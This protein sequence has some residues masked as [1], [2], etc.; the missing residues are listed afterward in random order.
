[1][2]LVGHGVRRPGAGPH[3]PYDVAGG[4]EQQ[5]GS[6]AEGHG[7]SGAPYS[8]TGCAPWPTDPSF[9]PVRVSRRLHVRRAAGER[10]RGDLTASL[11]PAAAGT[12][13]LSWTLIRGRARW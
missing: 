7:E 5:Q 9:V 1:M 10:A 6:G 13:A 3:P 12:V 11:L 4:G 2:R 8:V